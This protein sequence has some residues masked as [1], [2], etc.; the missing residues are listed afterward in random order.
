M[1]QRLVAEIYNGNQRL[2]NAYYH[3]SGYTIS[4]I[5]ILEQIVDYLEQHDY[6]PPTEMLAIRALE[7]TGAGL[8]GS[9]REYMQQEYPNIIFQECLGRSEGMIAI[10]EEQMSDY[11]MWNEGFFKIDIS[12]KTVAFDVCWG[13]YSL[14]E[15]NRYFEEEDTKKIEVIN[16]DINLDRVEYYQIEE[17]RQ[18]F[19][20][21]R[22][23]WCSTVIRFNV[24]D[25]E[26]GG[27]KHY[28]ARAID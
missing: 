22:E 15:S 24:D 18:L 1:G 2:A 7:A 11:F 26:N 5:D 16:S 21:A 12:N 9:S 3:W 14:E 4:S 17:M 10:T 19:E 13:N 28:Y 20:K 8:V 27:I 6:M 25:K 23:N